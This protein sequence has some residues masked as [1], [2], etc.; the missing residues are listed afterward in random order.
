MSK[1]S[2]AQSDQQEKNAIADKILAGIVD[3][4]P[5]LRER[6]AETREVRQVSD[7]VVQELQD[8]GVFLALH[9]KR[10]GG[11]ELDPQHFLK[12]SMA[13]AEGCTSTS[14]IA[15]IIAV[16]AFQLAL[17]DDRAQQDVWGDNIHTRTSSSYAPMGKAEP[18]EGGF[19]FSGRWGWSSGSHHCTW[20]LLGGIIPGEGYRTFLIPRSDYEIVDTWH[21]MGLQGTGSND[22]VVKD[23]FVPDYRTH[24]QMDGFN[25]TNPGYAVNDAPLYRVPWGQVFART[26]CTP[27]IGACKE[28][29]R[30]YKDLV[31]GK[32]SGDPTKLV[33]DVG[34]NERIAY[35]ANGIDE[36]ECILMR[37]FDVMMAKVNAGEE[38]L[39]DDRIL[40]RYQSSL[41]VEKAMAVVDHIYNVAGG[42]SVFTDSEIQQRFLDVHTARAHV[43]NNPTSF[44]RNLG[45]TQL[46]LDNTDVFL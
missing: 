10:Y 31:R 46:G 41:V 16:H 35:A 29:L 22:I 21:V 28:A 8:L 13:L 30:L 33:G 14:W 26:V 39:M 37:N 25:M 12:F 11:Y 40:Y 36:M 18:V 3:M 6:L 23:V 34:T 4:Q 42:R 17:M 32:A 43:A 45:A 27:T 15:G 19:K 7:E 24:K 2:T 44:A 20:V 1:Q 38:I 9:P 5:R